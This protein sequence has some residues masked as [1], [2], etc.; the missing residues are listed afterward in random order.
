M[1]LKFFAEIVLAGIIECTYTLLPIPHFLIFGSTSTVGLTGI[2]IAGVSLSLLP[3][4]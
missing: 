1:S 2:R 4:L 3:L